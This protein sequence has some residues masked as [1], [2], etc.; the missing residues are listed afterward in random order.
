[1]LGCTHQ[2][3]KRAEEGRGRRGERPYIGEQDGAKK[4]NFGRSYPNF[5]AWDE[6]LSDV[7]HDM[8][9]EPFR[10]VGCAVDEGACSIR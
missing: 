3:A 6:G 8:I 4:F 5:R 7:T 10:I 1:M 9:A 2:K